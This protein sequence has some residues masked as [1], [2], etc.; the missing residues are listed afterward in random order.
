MLTNVVLVI[1]T[2][3]VLIIVAAYLTVRGLVI[4]AVLIGVTAWPWAARA[5]RAQT[6]SLASRSNSHTN[7]AALHG[8]AA[9]SAANLHEPHAQL[10]PAPVPMTSPQL[11]HRAFTEVPD[12]DM[13]SRGFLGGGITPLSSMRGL[14]SYEAAAAEGSAERLGAERSLSET[15]LAGMWVARRR[16][17][18]Q[19]VASTAQ[20]GA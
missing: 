9:A 11:L 18:P 7:L 12:Y 17:A 4:E 15:D 19:R 8:S 2:L 14:P 1:P 16:G 6:F 5:I 3:A 13:A 10:P 20:L